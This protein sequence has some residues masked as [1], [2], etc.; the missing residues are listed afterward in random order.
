MPCKWANDSKLLL[1]GYFDTIKNSPSQVY[2]SI[3]QLSPPSSWLQRC[4]GVELSLRVKV[5]EGLAEGRAFSNSVSSGNYKEIMEFMKFSQKLKVCFALLSPGSG[6]RSD[7]LS[8]LSQLQN[9]PFSTPIKHSKSFPSLNS[10][11][12]SQTLVSVC[13]PTNINSAY[14]FPKSLK[15]VMMS[16]TSLLV[17]KRLNILRNPAC[18]FAFLTICIILSSFL[19]QGTLSGAV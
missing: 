17:Q 2:N 14:S 15:S 13:S 4:Y 19:H 1:S 5:V 8:P 12:K 16:H 10:N 6:I 7:I 3:L 18:K 11:L 9:I